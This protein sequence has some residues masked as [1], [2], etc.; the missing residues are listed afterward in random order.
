MEIPVPRGCHCHRRHI[1]R[2]RPRQKMP[3]AKTEKAFGWFV[4]VMGIYIILK[5]LFS[6]LIVHLPSVVSC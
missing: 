4:L 1:R 6:R 5:E 2:R 3:G